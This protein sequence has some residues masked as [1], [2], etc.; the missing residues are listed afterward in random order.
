MAG[1]LRHWDYDLF[2]IIPKVLAA[3]DRAAT[4]HALLQWIESLG[5]VAECSNC[6][7]LD[8]SKLL[9][10]PPIAWLSDTADLG[11]ALSKKLEVIYRNRPVKQFYL[12]QIPGVAN[13]DFKNEPAYASITKRDAG[14]QLLALFRFWNMIEY[15]SLYREDTGENRAQVLSEFIPRLAL[16]STTDK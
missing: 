3:V 16:V 13:P 5:E 1:G 11:D 7:K 15:W 6:T 2:R 14:Y 4:N 12:A 8:T 10:N 9:L